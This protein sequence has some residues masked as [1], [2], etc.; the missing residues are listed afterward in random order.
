MTGEFGI[1]HPEEFQ[2]GLE[3]VYFPELGGTRPCFVYSGK[4]LACC[5]MWQQDPSRYNEHIPQLY[6]SRAYF[7]VL[8]QSQIPAKFLGGDTKSCPH[9]IP[10]CP[11]FSTY[12]QYCSFHK[13]I[14]APVENINVQFFHVFLLSGLIN[15]LGDSIHTV[16]G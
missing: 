14:S 7:L 11:S 4:I 6:S 12:S 15:W 2:K 9:W 16:E 1:Q 5:Y 13:S 3:F 10:K 8:A